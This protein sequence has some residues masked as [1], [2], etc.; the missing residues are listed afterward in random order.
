MELKEQIVKTSRELFFKYGLRRITI[1]DIC[2]ELRIS[3]KTFYTVFKQ[4]EELILEVLKT[5]EGNKMLIDENA[6]FRENLE[7]RAKLI[8]NE[9]Q[10]EKH[11]N[12]F[13]DLEKYYPDAM[14]VHTKNAQLGMRK[15]LEIL[16]EIGRKEG[17]VR[18]HINYDF[19]VCIMQ[20]GII[21]Q[22]SYIRSKTGLTHKALA[23]HILDT[24]IRLVCTPETI[25]KYQ[26]EI[27]QNYFK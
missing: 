7:L 20:S 22:Y 15:G 17:V 26:Q 10:M 12:F 1:T 11:A 25:N 8:F 24:F 16:C 23:M 2:S 13:F 21:T 3:K 4:K 18:E 19:L 14:A 6:T 5:H 27:K 9:A